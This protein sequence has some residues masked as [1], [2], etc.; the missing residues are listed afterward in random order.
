MSALMVT[1][2]ASSPS[3]C[4]AASTMTSNS[5]RK[6]PF[7]IAYYR[8]KRTNAQ[9]RASGGVVA[10]ANDQDPPRSRARSTDVAALGEVSGWFGPARLVPDEEEHS[11]LHGGRHGAHPRIRLHRLRRAFRFA[12]R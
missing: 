3:R 4:S 5:P 10:H 11:P 9:G 2:Y 12:G 8:Q 1:A 7:G 6:S